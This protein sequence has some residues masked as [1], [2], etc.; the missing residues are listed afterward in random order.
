MNEQIKKRWVEALRSGNYQQG[1]GY[2][3][4]HAQSDGQDYYCCLG[5]LCELAVADGVVVRGE[6]GD[7]VHHYGPE[8]GSSAEFNAQLLPRTV[9]DWAGLDDCSPSVPVSD[10]RRGLADENDNG[11]SFDEIAAWIEEGL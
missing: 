7:Q 5:V 2:L 10:E 6:A 3:R 8:G 11:A 4:Q 1:I 9:A